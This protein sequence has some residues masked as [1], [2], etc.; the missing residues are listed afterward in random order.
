MT[1]QISL[2]H[3]PVQSDLVSWL[4]DGNKKLQ[5]QND[6]SR[7]GLKTKENI[8]YKEN[9]INKIEEMGFT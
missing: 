7:S 6:I 1:N 8:S 3:M 9:M 4:M 2:V 5:R